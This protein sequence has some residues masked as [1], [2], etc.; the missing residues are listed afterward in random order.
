MEHKCK[1]IIE[2]L[3]QNLYE[4]GWEGTTVATMVK[5]AGV[6]RNTFYE[7]FGSKDA[8]F[9]AMLEATFSWGADEINSPADLIDFIEEHYFMVHATMMCGPK[10]F[11]KYHELTDN[12]V[13]QLPLPPIKAQ[14]IIGGIEQLIKS[15][16]IKDNRSLPSLF[17]V[18]QFL[19]GQEIPA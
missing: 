11:K 17:D 6:A 2:A 12:V 7:C 9:E 13:K 18:E 8:A 10:H 1:R 3:A 16:L 14:L 4:L 5:T 15:T 19:R